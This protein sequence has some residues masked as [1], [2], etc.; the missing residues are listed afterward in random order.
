[1]KERFE[2]L[3]ARF[4]RN[5]W[6]IVRTLML[7][8]HI[9]LFATLSFFLVRLLPGDPV[10]QALDD[11]QEITPEAYARMAEIMGLGG[12]IM[13]QLVVFW[14]RL[15]RF[16][17]GVSFASNRP[18]WSEIFSRLPA[19]LELA[20]L[21]IFGTTLLCFALGLIYLVVENRTI[22]RLL[23][24]YAKLAGSVPDFAVAIFGLVV[25]YLWLRVLPPP[26]GLLDPGLSQSPITGAPL[27]DALLSGNWQVFSSIVRHLI[28]PIGV[29]V[30]VYTPTIWRQFLFSLDAAAR[31]PCTLFRISAGATRSSIYGSLIRRSSSSM[32][33]MI[34]ALYGGLIGGTVVLQ[35]LFN[36]GGLG[37][38]AVDAV[39]AVDFLVLQG[40]LIV[41]AATS[42]IVFFL[43][44]IVNMVLDPRRRP[45]VHIDG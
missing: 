21:A 15:L 4:A 28:L 6:W 34:G 23:H 24:F 25:F 45:G 18:V 10:L 16:D 27:L 17:L 12:N 40:I 2:R 22:Q 8:V 42:L 33:V 39:N 3:N 14:S 44:D 7:P 43:V 9:A 5:R 19:T 11:G 20:T 41:I 30:L 29:M 31:A 38:Y 35:Q 13:D 32:I 26:I 37:R 1:M 36:L